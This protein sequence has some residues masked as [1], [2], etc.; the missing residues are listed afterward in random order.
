MSVQM[1]RAGATSMQTASILRVLITVLARHI[2]SVMEEV[3]V[4]V[5]TLCSFVC[6]SLFPTRR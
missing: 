5:S 2:F 4:L 6:I 3:T 1:D